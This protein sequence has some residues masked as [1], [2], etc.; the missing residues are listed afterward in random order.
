[1][2]AIREPLLSVRGL[3]VR[4]AVPGSADARAVDGV[5][6]DLAAGEVLALLGE[7]GSGK[8]VTARAILGLIQR[9]GRIAAGSIRFEGR[10]LVGLGEAEYRRVRGREVALVFQDP[11]A[12]LNPVLTLG[13]QLCEAPRTHLGLSRGAAQ[14]RAA[15]LLDEL[16]LEDGVRWLGRY[17]HQLSGGQRQRAAL[18]QALAC[19]PKLVLADE[20]T[21]SL[22]PTL[23]AVV[24]ELLRRRALARSCAVLWITHDL[25]VARALAGRALVLYAGQVVE[26]GP[27]AELARA[28]RHPY[29]RALFDARLSAARRGEPLL[30][31]SEAAGD[32]TSWPSGCRFHPRCP[33]A[34]ALCARDAPELRT[35]GAR[36]VACHRPLAEAPESSP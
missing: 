30:A 10:E 4:F 28:P 6:F 31:P 29:T 11:P 18:A 23:V 21:T 22:D 13:E 34:D 35:D 7:S 17:P 3:D 19:E 8:S 1:M 16:G 36:A 9:P 15:T 25:R 5:S 26:S 27:M 12:A 32:P 14:A 24:V 33:L 2:A 20:P